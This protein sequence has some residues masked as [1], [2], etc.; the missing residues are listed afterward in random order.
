MS[1]QAPIREPFFIGNNSVISPIWIKFLNSLST[2]AEVTQTTITQIETALEEPL[3]ALESF[4]Y[5]LGWEEIGLSSISGLTVTFPEITCV[6]PDNDQIHFESWTHTFTQGKEY[7]VWVSSAGVIAYDEYAS[8]AT[9]TRYAD[10]LYLCRIITWP[11]TSVNTGIWVV[12]TMCDKIPVIKRNRLI[13]ISADSIINDYYVKPHD[14]DWAE[15]LDLKYQEVVRTSAGLLYMCLNP[16][17]IP[18]TEPDAPTITW[19]PYDYSGFQEFKWAYLPADLTVLR[20]IGKDTYEGAFKQGVVSGVHN[21]FGLSAAMFLARCPKEIIED[22]ATPLWNYV[23][24]AINRAVTVW[25]AG[26][27]YKYG[28]LVTGDYN[29]EGWVWQAQNDGTSDAAPVGFDVSPAPTPG[30]TTYTDNDITWKCV[31]RTSY[32]NPDV[33]WT[34][35]DTDTLM[36]LV[37]TPD[38]HD[39][40][41]LGLVGLVD[42][43]LRM[44]YLPDAFYSD[45]CEHG[46][47]YFA[48]LYNIVY[49][50]LLSQFE[51]FNLYPAHQFYLIPDGDQTEYPFFLFMDICG[52]WYTLA[53]MVRIM[54]DSRSPSIP[55]DI[56]YV[57]TFRDSCLIGVS[58]FW[59]DTE[60]CFTWVLDS[61]GNQMSAYNPI[62]VEA[63]NV[64][65]YPWIMAQYF[66][67]LMGV[68][69]GSYKTTNAALWAE[70]KFPYW[71][72]LQQESAPFLIGEHHL[73]CLIG[74]FTDMRRREIIDMCEHG[75]MDYIENSLV[76]T[77]WFH[78]L[79]MYLYITKSLTVRPMNKAAVVL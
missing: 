13:D 66:P 50:N 1:T 15:G 2:G 42:Q 38:S 35:M 62:I 34:I 25:Q 16:G 49:Y 75:K 10:K 39:G 31:G 20:Y 3:Y 26:H 24:N 74:D 12:W 19:E 45:N 68:P 70:S 51:S 67:I 22:L 14:Y 54:S 78:N 46:I 27:A 71:W 76:N 60:L 44:N 8:G 36:E 72:K 5:V 28:Q 41:V 43:L 40:G 32:H 52:G 9:H 29:F 61:S 47:T 18:L 57:E 48:A 23:K 7:S 65:G 63:E 56:T 58:K 53:A 11:T 37:T 30:T 33:N 69:C 6:F 59:D 17:R 79:S 4:P 64:W 73:G 55:A 77:K 21:I